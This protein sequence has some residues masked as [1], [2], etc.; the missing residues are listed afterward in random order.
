MYLGTTTMQPPTYLINPQGCMV[1]YSAYP[2]LSPAHRPMTG[3]DQRQAHDMGTCIDNHS[4]GLRQH[5]AEGQLGL[6]GGL[7]HAA[8]LIAVQTKNHM[9]TLPK[10]LAF[11]GRPVIVE[12]LLK[13]TLTFSCDMMNSPTRGSRVKP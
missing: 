7:V 1:P 11:T 10:Y 13:Y 12:V 2:F 8:A 3:Q 5:P 4:V 6:A 9:Y